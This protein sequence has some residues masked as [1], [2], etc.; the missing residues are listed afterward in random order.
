MSNDFPSPLVQQTINR[1]HHEQ[2]THS[3]LVK[4]LV[5]NAIN[6]TNGQ[7]LSKRFTSVWH[8]KFCVQH[9]RKGN[10]L[11]PLLYL[12]IT[13]DDQLQCVHH[14]SVVCNYL[15]WINSLRY[16]LLSTVIKM[17]VDSLVLS[18]LNYALSVWG[19]MLSGRSL[20]PLQRLLKLRVH[21]TTSL[22]KYD[23]QARLVASIISNSVSFFMCHLW[24][25]V[26]DYGIFKYHDSRTSCVAYTYRGK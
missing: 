7:P 8:F 4:P 3:P 24:T 23:H 25:R 18:C 19:L 11:R 20:W 2:I 22:H 1:L 6:C 16:S 26:S 14:I 10:F 17:L 5:Q 15:F 9:K 13:I 12:G 21:I